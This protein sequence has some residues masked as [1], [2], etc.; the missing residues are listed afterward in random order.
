MTWLAD[1]S[2]TTDEITETWKSQYESSSYFHSVLTEDGKAKLG[3]IMKPEV[4]AYLRA[5]LTNNPSYA[6]T[7]V[8]LPTH[9]GVN[10][11]LHFALESNS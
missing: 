5:L 9:R 1:K 6:T 10:E 3:N 11:D 7:P 2:K 4:L 8:P